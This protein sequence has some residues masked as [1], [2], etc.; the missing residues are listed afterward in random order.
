M[1]REIFIFVL[2]VGAIYI[3]SYVYNIMRLYANKGSTTNDSTVEIKY[4]GETSQ[5]LPESCTEAL[6][7]SRD[8]L[9]SR[10]YSD[11]VEEKVK[12]SPSFTF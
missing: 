6:L 12:D 9:D 3:W 4:A 11:Q 7:P 2:Q 5:T 1:T 10:D 8:C